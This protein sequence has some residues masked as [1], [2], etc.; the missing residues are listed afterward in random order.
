MS[1]N[2]LRPEDM[3]VQNRRDIGVDD[4]ERVVLTQEEHL[5]VSEMRRQRDAGIDPVVVTAKGMEVVDR[6]WLRA[7]ARRDS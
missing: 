2:L 5:V 1:D 4:L 7:S 6:L 3:M